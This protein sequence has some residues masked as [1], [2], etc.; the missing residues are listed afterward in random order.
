MSSSQPSPISVTLEPGDDILGAPVTFLYQGCPGVYSREQVTGL[1]VGLKTSKS[2]ERYLLIK[3]ECLSIPRWVRLQ[4]VQF[5]AQ[6]Q[7]TTE[8]AAA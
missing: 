7:T 5:L 6:K 3:T 2:G 1:V 8:V 4:D